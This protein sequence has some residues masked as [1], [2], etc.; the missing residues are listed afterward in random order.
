M[1]NTIARRER[2]CNN[3]P[4]NWINDSTITCWYIQLL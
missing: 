4:I 1:T 3:C 2:I